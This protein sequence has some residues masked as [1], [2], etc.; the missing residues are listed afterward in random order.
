LAAAPTTH[1]PP[2]TVGFGI[3]IS[4]NTINRANGR[5]GG[6]ISL[7]STWYAGPPP[8]RWPL[9][10]NTLIHHNTLLGLDAA[11][12]TACKGDKWHPRTGISLGGSELVWRSVLYANACPQARRPLNV[13][14]ADVVRVCPKGIAPSCECAP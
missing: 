11:P 8:Y 7:T 14:E 4:H 9:A 13:V 1:S 6:A 12:A 10:D 2:P 5:R 3:S